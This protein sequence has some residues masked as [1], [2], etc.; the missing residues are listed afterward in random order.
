MSR[1]S[2]FT[3]NDDKSVNATSS[4]IACAILLCLVPTDLSAQS[5]DS[6]KDRFPIEIRSGDSPFEAKAQWQRLSSGHAGCEGAQWEIRNGELTLMYAAHHD[7]L[8]YR[9]TEASGLTVWRDDS[10]EATAFRPD[11]TG[12]YYV[13]EQTTR[14]L[15]RWDADGQRVE[16]LADRFNGKRLNRPNDCVVHSDGSVWFTDPDWLFKQRSDDAKELDGQ[17]VFCFDPSNGS[18]RKVA[19]G[20]NKP[21]GIAFSPDEKWLF[22]TDSFANQ[23]YR[24][25]VQNSKALGKREVFAT[26]PDVGN[27]GITFDTYGRLWCCTRAG[28][29]I[30]NGAGETVALVKTP[31][32]PTSVAFAPAPSR[33]VCV[34]T[35]DACYI[36]ELAST[37]AAQRAP[38]GIAV[39]DKKKKSEQLFVR[40]VA[41]LLRE[42]CLG[43]HGNKPDEIE[44][45]L[46]LRTLEGLL[47]GGDSE[48]ASIILGKPDESPLY[49]ASTR[50]SDDWSAMPPKEA[51]Q[52]TTEQ[53]NWLSEWIASGAQWPDTERR[54]EIEEEYA[55]EW[56]V[57]DGVAVKTSGGLADEWTNRKYDP[58]GLWAYKPLWKDEGGSL[59][60]TG[61]N[62]IDLLIGNALPEGLAVAPRADRRTL[63]RRAT[64]DLTGLPPTPEEVQ[65][66][67]NDSRSDREAF[68]RVIDRLLKSP[69]Y[70]E[71]MAQ[72]W[73]DVVRYANSSGFANDYERGNAWRYR[74]YV[75][76]A[77][78]EDKPYNEFIREQIAGDEIGPDDPEKI[79]ATGF[80]RMG[81]WELTGMEVA[82]VARQRFL[83][84][85]TNSVG[86]TFLAHSLQCARCHDH[87]FDPV[88]TRDYYSIQ[89]V[90]ATTQLAEREAAFLKTE[91][92]TGFEEQSYLRETLQAHQQTLDE[93]DRVLLQNA[94]EWFHD[95]EIS[96]ERWDQA[97]ARMKSRGRKSGLF[98]AARAAL[99]KTGVPESEYPPKLVGFTPKQFGQERVARKGIERLKWELE[100]YEPYALAVYNG[101]TRNVNGVYA[102]TRVP[103][104]RHK[105]GELEQTAI[106]TGGDPFSPGQPVSPGTLSVV[107]SHLHATIPF[108]MEGRRTAFANWV[109][110]A[111]NPLTPR[112]I[113]NRLW[114]W[115]FGEAIAGNP[116]NF[117]STG[118]RPTHP[119]LLDWLASTFVEHG[120]SVKQ[121]HRLI[122]TSDA[123]C[124]SSRHPRIRSLR[125]FDPEGKSYAVFQPRR[126]SAE[127]LRDSML[128]VSGE[129]NRTLGGIPCRPEINQE[130]ALQPRQVMGTFAAAWTPNPKP[131]QRNRRSIYVLR[132][133]GLLDPMLEVFNTPSP[134][135][136]CEQRETSTVTPQVF[137]LFNGQNT[138]SRSL[139]L[140]ARVLKETENDRDAIKRCFQLVL[141]REP[142]LEEVDEFLAHWRRTEQALPE[143]RPTRTSPPLEVVRK[144]VEENTGELFT[145]TE[146]LYS[147]TDFVPD[148]QPADVDRRTRALSDVCLVMLNSNEFVYVY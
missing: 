67:L 131:Q 4:F 70:G 113:V 92:I 145:F 7:H 6:N 22:V 28:I 69:Q 11:G 73:L 86:E 40:R 118:K 39:A 41:P 1:T 79:V 93:L 140:A 58:A 62:P 96:S 26:F 85:V 14:Q 65:E 134:D 56:S 144:A 138:H 18:I 75:V 9:W 89:A 74:D 101:R 64:F 68:S 45:S 55:K 53:L 77:F 132:L 57:E 50:Q 105:Q 122:M 63:I 21:N 61:R 136:S 133:R 130:V 72:H 148:L 82:K 116:N 44:G 137:S 110:D 59:K 87:K 107:N 27:D 90:F 128:F 95:Q 13:V 3:S 71:R 33:K 135:F 37:N 12:G 23:L 106:L 147:N 38:L 142:S 103:E 109:A 112:V 32:K 126:L 84:D 48:E 17:F 5:A 143:E 91:N 94:Q 121:M 46:D 78:N 19:D 51:E 25:P 24:W 104:D 2:Q 120:W 42:K 117:G 129:L 124:R 10:P 60:K 30:L 127:E 54:K 15:A 114:L 141:S 125:E 119:R 76:R 49:L 80:L 35:R 111:K 146:R 16:I 52:L 31:N 115:H 8:A 100:R 29:V 123:Y 81:P 20:L 43:C 102:P 83:D 139:A 99:A 47:A 98:N 34:T 88:P 36:T 97:V 66:F 108:T